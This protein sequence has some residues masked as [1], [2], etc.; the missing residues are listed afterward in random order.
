MGRKGRIPVYGLRFTGKN[1]GQL[2]PF[3]VV[4][5]FHD[6]DFVEWVQERGEGRRETG[7]EPGWF[8]GGVC[9]TRH[10]VVD[11][12]YGSIDD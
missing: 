10:Q 4:C 7:K 6:W 2:G 12:F 3:Q 1:G 5:W 11:F 8:L 9:M